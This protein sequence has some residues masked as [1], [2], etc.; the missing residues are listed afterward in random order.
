M[1]IFRAERQVVEGDDEIFIHGLSIF[2]NFENVASRPNFKT[3][4]ISCYGLNGS[5]PKETV[6]SVRILSIHS[7]LCI[8][9][10]ISAVLC[11]MY[12]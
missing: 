9:I 3:R 11:T 5:N 12:W 1:V 8:L 10:K 2:E 6:R 7:M 4:P